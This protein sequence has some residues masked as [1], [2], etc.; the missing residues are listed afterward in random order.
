MPKVLQ[1][2][3]TSTLLGIATGIVKSSFSRPCQRLVGKCR[4]TGSHALLLLI[5][6]CSA[7]VSS[8]QACDKRACVLDVPLIPQEQP[9]WC[10]AASAQMVMWSFGK[11]G[12]EYEQCTQV[13]NAY[14]QPDC[15]SNPTRKE[16]SKGG[17]PEFAKYGFSDF[18]RTNAAA[19][20]QKQ[21]LD[22]IF[23]QRKPFAFS[24]KYRGGGGHIMVIIGYEWVGKQLFL[25]VNDPRDRVEVRAKT[26]FLPYDEYVQSSEYSHWDD[27][28][29]LVKAAP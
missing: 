21:I 16:C 10:W 1:K 27:F 12:R 13:A 11:F 15:C 9:Y 29:D 3:S 28:Y 14:M 17:W 2:P 6:C 24:W 23:S 19:L 8:A 26:K 22:H 4:R 18:K 20:T 25:V 5:A 7:G